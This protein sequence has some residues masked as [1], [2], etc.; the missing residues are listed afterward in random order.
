MMKNIFEYKGYH[1]KI[2]FD[3]ENMLLYGKIEGIS[4]LITFEADNVN[5]IKK[6]FENAVDDYLEF[7]K[8]VG[9]S[10]E[11]EYKGTFNIR[12][13]PKLHREIALLANKNGESLNQVVERAIS[14]YMNGNTQSQV[15]F[16]EMYKKIIAMTYDGSN[17][18]F[19]W[20]NVQKYGGD[21]YFGNTEIENVKM[22]YK[23]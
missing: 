1:T 18:Q 19:A 9:K 4:D 20:G 14:S 15:K 7:C 3:A 23:Q 10:P 2:D 21:L 12:I 11:K 16:E 22:K 5:N 13:S 17:N 8:E 6:E